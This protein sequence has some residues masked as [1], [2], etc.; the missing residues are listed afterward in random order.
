MM[1]TDM[2]DTNSVAT[3]DGP[4]AD[5]P[6][7]G[8][9][10]GG[11]AEIRRQRG[12]ALQA[13]DR[14]TAQMLDELERQAYVVEEKEGPTGSEPPDAGGAADI[15]KG[16]HTPLTG[17]EVSGVFDFLEEVDPEAAASLSRE[18][19]GDAAANL[20][21]AHRWFTT[22]YTQA[23]RDSMVVTPGL[24]SMAARMGRNLV[25]EGRKAPTGRRG[26]GAAA[27]RKKP[28]EIRRLKQ[29]ALRKGDYR[30]AQQYDEQERAAYAR[31]HGAQPIVGR[32]GRNV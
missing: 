9:D 13:G 8:S 18:W 17:D 10:G 4:Q 19:G 23:E 5:S 26:G 31:Q 15:A 25:A 2:T 12:D 24:V 22:Q 6:A 32:A 20:G 3:A 7:D 28:G 21:Y 14:D 1:E 11:V 30:L 16:D 29:E 27:S